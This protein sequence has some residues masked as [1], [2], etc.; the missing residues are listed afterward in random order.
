MVNTLSHCVLQVEEADSHT[1]EKLANFIETQHT[2]SCGQIIDIVQ[3]A[4]LGPNFTIQLCEQLLFRSSRSAGSNPAT[5]QKE[6]EVLMKYI[7]V[8]LR[9]GRFCRDLGALVTL[10]TVSIIVIMA[11]AAARCSGIST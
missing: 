9:A 4:G 8:S 3:E 2:F 5:W 6:K 10:N 1:F 7:Q 11:C